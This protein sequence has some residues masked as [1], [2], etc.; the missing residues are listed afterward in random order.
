MSLGTFALLV[1]LFVV[2]LGLLALGHRLR[3]RTRAQRAIFWGGLTGYLAGS[4]GAL[5]V[6]MVP[7]AEWSGA[8][9]IRG[10]LGYWGL[11]A[12][13]TLGALAALVFR[14]READGSIPRRTE[15]GG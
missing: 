7:A 9:T 15:A 4:L 6:G 2:P 3:R 14:G 12:G 8:D 1:G 10:L 11:I 13:P 5:W